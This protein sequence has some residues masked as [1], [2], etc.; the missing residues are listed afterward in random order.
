VSC[1]P[2]YRI[3]CLVEQIKARSSRYT[4]QEFPAVRSRIPTL[5]ANAY[6]V[7]TVGGAPLEIVKQYLANQ[8]NA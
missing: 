4:R 2:R 1:D 6:F 7:A 3:H 8:R 5:R